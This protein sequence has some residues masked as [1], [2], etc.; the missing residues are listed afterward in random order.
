MFRRFKTDVGH[1]YPI[2]ATPD[3][4]GVN[5]SIYSKNATDI[6][7]PTI[8]ATFGA[9]VIGIIC[10]KLLIRISPENKKGKQKNV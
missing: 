2:G 6:I 8:L 5:F 1:P 3:K 4:N 9:L 7:L 10:V